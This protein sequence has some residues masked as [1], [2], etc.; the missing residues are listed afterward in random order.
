MSHNII[1]KVLIL[2]SES[3]A[4]SNFKKIA[5]RYFS[6]DYK[7]AVGVNILSKTISVDLYGEEVK[8]LISLWDISNKS[9]FEEIRKI[10]Y[11]GSVGALFV[12][13]LS[14]ISSWYNVIECYKEVESAIRNIPFLVIGNLQI[15]NKNQVKIPEINTWAEN[16]DGVFIQID[17][18][19]TTELEK[20]FKNL[21]SKI[22]SIGK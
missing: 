19:D 22:M 17:P 9:R 3:V 14:E 18:N 21:I 10:F 4:K 8:I 13:N 2:G 7:P 15:P 1:I 12:F 20:A 5:D 11:K 6:I 16:H